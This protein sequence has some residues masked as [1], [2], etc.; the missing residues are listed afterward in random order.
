M[1][2]FGQQPEIPGSIK[3]VRCYECA[4]I[5]IDL[6]MVEF[7]SYVASGPHKWEGEISIQIV[8]GENGDVESAKGISGHPYFRPMLEKASLIAKFKPPVVD[9]KVV[10][11]KAVIFYLI[12]LPQY[13]KETVKARAKLGSINGRAIS[14]P[15]P[16]YPQELKDLCASGQIKVEVEVSEEGK[17]LTATPFSGDEVLF[18]TA[19]T[20]AQAATF[21]SLTHAV[22]RSKG[23]VVYNFIPE[24]KCVDVGDVYGRWRERPQFSVHPH[25]IIQVEMEVLVRLGIDVMNGKVIAAKAIGGHPLNWKA[26]EADALKIIFSPVT[27]WPPNVVGKGFIRLR[28]KP[29][30][31]VEP[32]R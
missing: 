27:H 19:R 6:P 32:F 14:L 29:D 1:L 3:V 23:I 22:V 24:G 17:V 5:V 26:F 10:K 12:T 20:A 9:G 31:T 4:D 30:R 2:V 15:K 16:E 18:D 13:V 8:I 11:K 28:I 21:R 7:P 25:S